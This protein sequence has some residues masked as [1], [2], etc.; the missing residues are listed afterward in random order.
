MQ[1]AHRKSHPILFSSEMVRA[2]LDGSKTQTR[3]IVKLPD[4]RDNWKDH[5]LLKCPYGQVDERLWVRETWCRMSHS[6]ECIGYKADKICKCGHFFAS[7]PERWKPSIHMRREYSRLTLK[8]TDVSIERLQ[9]I[10]DVDAMAEGVKLHDNT[11]THYQGQYVDGFQVL[12]ESIHGTD[13]WAINP[14]V[15]AVSFERLKF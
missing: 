7:E 1:L 6:H 9:D 12:W 5:A 3:R 8:I 15:Y 10:S 14:W 13:S 2:I 11:V 4:N